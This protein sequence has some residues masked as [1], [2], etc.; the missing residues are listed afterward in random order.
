MEVHDAFTGALRAFA[1]HVPPA[2]PPIDLRSALAECERWLDGVRQCRDRDR[3]EK[4]WNTLQDEAAWLA[5][6]ARKA[7]APPSPSERAEVEPEPL[8]VGR[9][10]D[11]TGTLPCGHQAKQLDVYE[12][13]PY[14]PACWNAEPIV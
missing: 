14:C 8:K 5:H 11:I 6:I 3:F 1:P 13:R 7:L 9:A 12:G 10:G 4:R 2:E